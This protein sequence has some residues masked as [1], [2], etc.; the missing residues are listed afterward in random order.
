VKRAPTRQRVVMSSVALA[1]VIS[2]AATACG[3]GSSSKSGSGSGGSGGTKVSITSFT[4]SFASLSV[5]V[6]NRKGYFTKDGIDPSFINV[7]SGSAAMQ[8]MLAGS[9]NMANVAIF[10]SLQAA[11][12]GESTKY[13]V[14]AATS[15]LGELVVGKNVPLPDK[16]AGYP[17]VVKDLKG[18]K[19][20]I[21]SKSSATYY[22]LALALE[23]AGLDPNKDVTLV[24]AGTLSAQL[25]ALKAGQIDAFMAQE[26]TTT[27][28]VSG[29]D[30]TVVFRAYAGNRPAVFDDLIT[31]GVAATDSYIQGHPAAVKGVHDAVAEAD[32]YIAGL[33]QAGITALATLVS[34]DFPGVS[35][36]TLTQAIAH[37]QKLYSATISQAGVTAAN[38]VLMDFGAIK[39]AIPYAKV[40]GP[41][42]QGS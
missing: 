37:Y 2:L 42:A 40:V 19:I 38:K 14:G 26:P 9:A 15:T 3:S 21:S 8:A 33:D 23:G 20:G 11:A 28:A 7:S 22:T 10:E 32:T 25:T 27:Q 39:T 30:G 6:A 16:A 35:K 18:K 24:N 34:P 31:N 29:G 5:Y 41:T 1:A 13:I 36:P 12:K 4:G 17:A